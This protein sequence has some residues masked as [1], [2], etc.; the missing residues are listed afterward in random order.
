MK[1]QPAICPELLRHFRTVS[2]SLLAYFE[3]FTAAPL[4]LPPASRQPLLSAFGFRA[5]AFG[6]RA[7]GLRTVGRGLWMPLPCARQGQ[8]SQIRPNP[9]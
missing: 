9:T 7:P 3:Y 1:P 6:L 5:S 2:A 4:P 8:S